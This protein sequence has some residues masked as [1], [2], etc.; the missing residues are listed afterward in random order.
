MKS[1]LEQVDFEKIKQRFDAFWERE[2]IDR[3]IIYI[4]APRKIQKKRNF[5]VPNTVEKRCT[6]IEYILNKMML[7]FDNTI[8]LGDAL[9]WYFPNIGPDSFT[10]FLGGDLKFSYYRDAFLGEIYTSK[11][12]PFVNDLT[13]YNPVLDKKN[14]WWIFMNELL[15]VLCSIAKDNFLVAIPDMHGGADSIATARGFDNLCIDIIEKQNEVKRVMKKLTKIYYEI[16]EVYYNKISSVGNGLITW[17]PAYSK[18]K[19]AALDNDDF[20]ALISPKMFEEFFLYEVKEFSKYFD[21]SIYHLDGPNSLRRLDYILLIDDLNCIQWVQ[22]EGNSKPMEQWIDVCN[23][24]LNS[25][26]C[27]QIFCDP[28]EVEFLLSEL[29]HEGLFLWVGHCESEDQA[30]EL[31]KK[32][33]N[34]SY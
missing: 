34:K 19:W 29:K 3:P 30:Y 7:N 14:K 17:I 22:G 15:D 13:K 9:P 4:T 27:I 25:G 28:N 8:Y 2:I 20:A 23:K 26:K 33:E 16:Y 10:A 1:Y 6:D 11:L 12:T 31:L 5:L 32:V 24:V 18:R 21:N